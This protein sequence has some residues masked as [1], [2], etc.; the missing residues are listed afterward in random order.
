MSSTKKFVLPVMLRDALVDLKGLSPEACGIFVKFWF[1]HEMHRE[2]L[3]PREEKKPAGEWDEWFRAQMDLKSVRVWKRVRDELLAASKIRRADDGR[4]YIGRTMRAVAEKRGEDPARWGGESDQGS[5]L[6]EG[7]HPAQERAAP[8]S[9]A[10]SPRGVDE[11]VGRSVDVPGEL[12]QSGEIRERL[13]EVSAKFGPNSFANPLIFLGT[14][15]ALSYSESE[16]LHELL[17]Q[18]SVSARARG[19]PPI[20]LA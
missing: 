7:V 4:L 5:L 14:G 12:R 19:S 11:V 17:L 3:P 13:P 6:L 10:L 9:P 2:P 16:S 18:R 1:L 15:P 8:L 20:G